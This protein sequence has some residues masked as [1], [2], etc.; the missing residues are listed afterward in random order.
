MRYLCIFLLAVSSC[1]CST[2]SDIEVTELTV[3]YEVSWSA[4]TTPVSLIRGDYDEGLMLF[5]QT[6]IYVGSDNVFIDTV[7]NFNTKF[8]R[9]EGSGIKI[10]KDI[11][12]DDEMYFLLTDHEI[13]IQ[14]DNNSLM[15]ESRV[16]VFGRVALVKWKSIV[17]GYKVVLDRSGTTDT[18]INLDTDN[19]KHKNM[20][21]IDNISLLTS[22][23]FYKIHADNTS[24]YQFK[25]NFNF[26][27]VN[28]ITNITQI[29]GG[30]SQDVSIYNGTVYN[31]EVST[32]NNNNGIFAEGSAGG[33][34][35]GCM[36]R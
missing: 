15:A 10:K 6:E 1:F 36:L 23:T 32:T 29:I 9:L 2:S 13:P 18:F 5:S 17:D 31:D 20:Y 27:E 8:Y 7:G 33:G 24:T 30:L 25:L 35:G 26:G 22:A 3:G 14:H 4:T 19:F 28:D 12:I 34:G 11:N 21:I 16:A